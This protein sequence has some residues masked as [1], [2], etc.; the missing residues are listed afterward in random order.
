MRLGLPEFAPIGKTD[1]SRAQI[2]GGN[3]NLSRTRRGRRCTLLALGAALTLLF[4]ALP[5]F[6]ASGAI[7]SLNE[8]NAVSSTKWLNGGDA[9]A[10]SVGGQASDITLG[11]IQGN[12]GDWFELVLTEPGA[13]LRGWQFDIHVLGVLDTTLVLSQDV[14]WTQLEA[15]TIITVAETQ[16]EDVSYDPLAGDW[17]INVQASAGSSGTYITA[18]SFPV[19]NEDWQLV[20]RDSAGV[21]QFGPS[22]EGIVATGGVSSTEIWRL[23]ENPSAFIVESSLCFDD[24]DTYSTF[25]LPNRWASGTKIQ[26]FAPLRN[27]TAPTTQCNDSD[28]TPMAFD[29][30]RIIEVDVLMDPADYEVLRRQQRNLMEVFSGRCGDQ[31]APDPYTFFRADVTV[32]GT[33]VVDA[34][35]RKKGFFGSIDRHKPS[36]KIDF[37]E[38]GN[39]MQIYGMDRLTLNNGRQDPSLLDVCLGYS[40]YRG[41][42]LVASRCSFAHVTLNGESL[43]IYVNVEAIKNPFLV[44]KYGDST[45]N[46]YEGSVADFRENW[47]GVFEKKNNVDGTDLAAVAAA[48]LIEDDAQALAAI[49]ALVDFDKFLT[50]WAMDGLVGNWDGYTGGANNFWIYNNPAT[51]L[52]EFLPWSLDDIFGRDSPFTNP[53]PNSVSRTVFDTAALSNRL[54]QIASVR[55]QYETRITELVATVWDET[56]LLAEIDRM[57]ALITPIAGD[58]SLP[59]AETR[60]W[61]SARAA[62]VASDF[63]GGPPSIQSTLSGKNCLQ[64]QG[65]I[66]ADFTT[67]FEDPIGGGLPATSSFTPTL[68]NYAGNTSLSGLG[69]SFGIAPQMGSG[70]FVLRPIGLM[71]FPNG[72]MFNIS[73]DQEDAVVNSPAPIP[74]SD[75]IASMLFSIDLSGSGYSILGQVV[76]TSLEINQANLTQGGAVSGTFRSYLASWIPH[77]SGVADSDGDLFDDSVDNCIYI[78]NPVQANLDGD[79]LGDVCDDDRDGDGVF[80]IDDVFPDDPTESTDTDGDGVG[81]NADSDDDGDLLDDSDE[82]ALGTDPLNPDSD[83]DGISDGAEVSGGSDPTD[84][85]DPLGITVPGLSP[86]GFWLL[87]LSI[88]ALGYRRFRRASFEPRG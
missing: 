24:A 61:I 78:P 34:G 41:A 87:V 67:E 26:D 1:T 19:N 73:I 57:E 48:L 15:G 10:D 42:G 52:F 62:K 31:P 2:A 6:S 20:I 11:R 84:P 60:S 69:A 9:S 7:L 79:L 51:G 44:R 29:P 17:V 74:I 76:T 23:E 35:I 21:I 56:A 66:Q 4:S 25:G 5:L 8:Y 46:L 32:D 88:T 54:W 16:P 30:D 70:K 43:G 75:S 86:I 33:T 55:Q 63:S 64:I 14:L 22:G 40:L 68:F 81:N 12:G 50:F 65:E 49:S 85:N 3:R 38:F 82:V 83:G 28:L 77:P 13:D 47:I 53:D 45:G 37:G 72:L 80:N 59:I 71:N 36:F 58:L 27:G 18:S 39:E